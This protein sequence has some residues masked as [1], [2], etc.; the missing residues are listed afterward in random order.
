MARIL[1]LSRQ[2]INTHNLCCYIFIF[3]KDFTLISYVYAIFAS[4]L[5]I[6][7]WQY[8]H[9]V[10][11][12]VYYLNMA[13]CTPAGSFQAALVFGHEQ[14]ER[15]H[16]YL[17]SIMLLIVNFIVYAVVGIPL[18]NVVFGSLVW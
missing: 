15:K 12:V 7:R 2:M 1:A 4:A 5:P 16:A 8:V 14:M 3:L 11:Y 18:G 6:C 10:V 9:S 13:Y 17:Y